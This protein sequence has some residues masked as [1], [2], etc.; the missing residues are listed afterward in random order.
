MGDN[1]DNPEHGR[2][3]ADYD[4]HI[5]PQEPATEQKDETAQQIGCSGCC[6]ECDEIKLKDLL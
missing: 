6:T 4:L 1:K 5:E 3:I 2:R